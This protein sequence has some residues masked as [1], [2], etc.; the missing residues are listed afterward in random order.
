MILNTGLPEERHSAIA[1][2]PCEKPGDFEAMCVSPEAKKTRQITY[3]FLRK[4]E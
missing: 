1:I 2:E 4:G 3:T